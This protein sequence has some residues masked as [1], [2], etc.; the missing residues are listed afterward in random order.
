MLFI[1][2]IK[3]VALFKT[4]EVTQTIIYLFDVYDVLTY[5]LPCKIQINVI[6]FFNKE[7]SVIKDTRYK[8]RIV[9][10]FDVY[11]VATLFTMYNWNEWYLFLQY[12]KAAL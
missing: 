4:Q 9:Y 7:S 10:L 8:E 1:S 5:Y 12:K 2:S 6:Y 11:D 3:K